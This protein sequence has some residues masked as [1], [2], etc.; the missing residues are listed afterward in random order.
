V[1]IPI[2]QRGI[3]SLPQDWGHRIAAELEK[4]S[5]RS[6]TR[7]GSL[8]SVDIS[9]NGTSANQQEKASLIEKTKAQTIFMSGNPTGC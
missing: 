9:M 1:G 6:K 7:R 8:M 3:T 4:L 2:L 5:A